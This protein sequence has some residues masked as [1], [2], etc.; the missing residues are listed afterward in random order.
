[1]LCSP[2]G[3]LLSCGVSFSPTT[4]TAAAAGEL[5]EDVFPDIVNEDAMECTMSYNSYKLK[6]VPG[7]HSFFYRRKS[8]PKARQVGCGCH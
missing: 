8:L 4:P 3:Y 6:Y 7:G 1:M 5:G 2:S